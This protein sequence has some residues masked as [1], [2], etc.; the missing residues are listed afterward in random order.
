M[1]RRPRKS[2]Y[3]EFSFLPGAFSTR[4]TNPGFPINQVICY[5]QSRNIYSPNVLEEQIFLNA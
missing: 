5:F 3:N 4:R 1:S 2:A